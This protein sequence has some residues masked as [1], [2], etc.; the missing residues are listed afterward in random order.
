MIEFIF[1][2]NYWK[3]SDKVKQSDCVVWDKRLSKN[4]ATELQ[5]SRMPLRSIFELHVDT[6]W[7]GQDHAGPRFNV[8]ILWFFFNFK[9]YNVNHWNWDEGRFYTKEEMIVEWQ[10]DNDMRIEHDIDE[11]DPDDKYALWKE[12]EYKVWRDTVYPTI[13]QNKEV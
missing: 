10:E 9:I 2:I 12:I 8:S 1:R 3:P 5:I 11:N 6:S 13:T 7:T 4:W